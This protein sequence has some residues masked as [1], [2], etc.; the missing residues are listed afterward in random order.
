MNDNELM[1]FKYN[2]DAII[3][4]YFTFFTNLDLC[5]NKIGNSDFKI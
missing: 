3:K 4:K 1:E 2:A 5:G